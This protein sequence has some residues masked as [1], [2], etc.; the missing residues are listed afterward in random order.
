MEMNLLKMIRRLKKLWR[1][2]EQMQSY[3]NRFLSNSCL[4]VKSRRRLKVL[5]TSKCRETE[6]SKEDYRRAWN[7]RI[8]IWERW[9][10][11]SINHLRTMSN[12]SL[13]WQMQPRTTLT[14]RTNLTNTKKKS[15]NSYR[16]RTRRS[17]NFQRLRQPKTKSTKHSVRKSTTWKTT[18]HPKSPTLSKTWRT[19]LTNNSILSRKWLRSRP[20]TWQQ[21]TTIKNETHY[22]N[23]NILFT[24]QVHLK[25]NGKNVKN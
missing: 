15:V 3:W 21:M 12:S 23:S 9:L 13:S 25:I 5:L 16:T 14:W 10:A 1:W 24:K 20:R 17:H 4:R 22:E 8:I 19:C 11:N 6:R 7:K 2:W 18:F